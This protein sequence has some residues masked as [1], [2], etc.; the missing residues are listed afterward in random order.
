MCSSS[1]HARLACP[2]VRLPSCINAGVSAAAVTEQPDEIAA[3]IDAL[4][5]RLLVAVLQ[6]DDQARTLARVEI[7]RLKRR[8]PP[9]PRRGAAR[10]PACTA[11]TRRFVA[12]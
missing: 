1:R 6:G 5:Q 12:P 9:T 3:R 11:G 7:D 10:S 2:R 4:E 8:L